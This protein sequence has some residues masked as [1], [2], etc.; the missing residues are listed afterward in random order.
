MNDKL[1]LLFFSFLLL[2]GILITYSNHWHSDFHFD[3]AHTVQ[4]NVYIQH[5]SN[6]PLFYKDPT[7][8]SSIPSHCSYRPLVTT[9]LAIDYYLGKGLNPFYFHLS[10]FIFFLLQGILMYF[11]FFKMLQAVSKNTPNV[12]ISLFAT[13]LYMLHPTLAE[14]VNYVISRSDTLSTLFVVMAFVVYQYSAVARK[15]Y[16][17]LIPVLIGSLAK[18]T[19]IMF[20]PMLVVY[21]ILFEQKS[22]LISFWKLEWKKLLLIAIPSFAVT[23]GFYLFLTHKEEGL[24][25]AG[26]YSF[27]R[28]FITQPFV[29]VHYISQFLLPT[30]LSAD[31]D[32]GTFESL[33]NPK[34]IIGFV[35]LAC[36]IFAIFF[37]SKFERWRP[38]SFGLSWFLLALVPTT[39]VPLAEVMNDHRI[40]FPF[41][42]LSFALVWTLYLLLENFMKKVPSLA[43]AAILIVIL[44]GYS[45]GTYLRNEIWKTDEKLWNDVSIKS[46]KNGRGLMNYGLVFMGRASYDTA[47]YYFTK[48]LDYCPQYSLLHVNL[49]VLKGAMGDKIAAE[50][51]FKSG[52]SLAPNEAGNYYFYARFLR[53]NGRK[54]EAIANLY[55]CLR[56]VDS[57]MDARSMLMPLLFE[58]KR[59]EE[60]KTVA[61]RTMELSPNDQTASLYLKMAGSGKSQLE[62]EEENSINYKTPEQFLNLSLLYYNAANYEGCISAAKKALALKPDY[63]EA[64]N[65]ICTAYNALNKFA[66][67]A[68]ACE[69]ALK[70]KPGYALASGNLKYAKSKLLK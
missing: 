27:F 6:I 30:Q 9:T 44:C 29:F 63:A 11:M 1:K 59:F 23:I 34:A 5:L 67:G 62:V 28:Y 58:E 24:F 64:Y 69:A 45:Y 57:R 19:A 26:G 21:H 35:F 2:A 65:N 10:T 17:Y 40:F 46:P 8:F 68:K 13:A 54:D 3:D 15:F 42:G 16:L 56:I 32:W 4:N 41:V 70:I 14:T 60:L 55:S 51:Y 12:F 61:A 49:A 31:T 36:M 22:D 43:L 38:V 39:F 53:D 18:P 48:A 25:E 52:I 37:L 66:E 20:A 50:N 47:N 7:T 33:S